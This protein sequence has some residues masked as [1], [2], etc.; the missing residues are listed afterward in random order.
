MRRIS[1]ASAATDGS[2]WFNE[3]KRLIRARA[4]AEIYAHV[5]KEFAQADAM[6]AVERREVRALKQKLNARNSGRVRP[7]EW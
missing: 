6:T 2:A 1:T 4:K 5:I 7:K 3:G